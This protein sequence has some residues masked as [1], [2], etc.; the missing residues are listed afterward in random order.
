MN[1]V[2]KTGSVIIGAVVVALALVPLVSLLKNQ[3]NSNSGENTQT[4][5]ERY[6]D[7]PLFV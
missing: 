6:S 4:F 1:K 5:E 2:E 7:E 3:K